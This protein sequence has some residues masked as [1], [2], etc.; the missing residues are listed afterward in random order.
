MSDSTPPGPNECV[1]PPDVVPNKLRVSEGVFRFLFA[2]PAHFTSAFEKRDFA[3]TVVFRS[4][5]RRAGAWA[6]DGPHAR[7]TFMLSFEVPIPEKDTAIVI[8]Q[9]NHVGEEVSALIGAFFGKLV[10]NCGHMQSG[11]HLTVPY[12]WDGA[13]YS[14]AHPAFNQHPRKP[15][16]TDLQLTHVEKLLEGYFYQGSNNESLDRILRSAEF[17]RM[18]LENFHERP[19]MSF[20]FLLSALEAMLDLHHYTDDEK[21]DDVLRAQLAQIAAQCEDGEKLVVSLKS[22]FYQIRRRVAAFVDAYIPDTFFT[23]SEARDP[24]VSLR[25]REDLRPRMLAA[26]DVRSRLLHTG[27][28]TGIW[29][30]THSSIGE[31]FCLGTPVLG[32]EKLKRLI[33]S[34]LSL[35][36]LERVTST[37]LRA[38]V[39]RHLLNDTEKS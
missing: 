7:S 30:L 36:G 31:E 19:E 24:W 3:L 16:G 25:K 37:V 11:N 35:V 29:A 34:S 17:Y 13:C 4:F 32:E 9:Y 28:R 26:Y 39:Q 33:T 8:P 1:P 22:R 23:Q 20:T 2:S 10:V 6:Y 12:M 5:D 21:Y 15:D 14:H 38:A 18:A 27:D